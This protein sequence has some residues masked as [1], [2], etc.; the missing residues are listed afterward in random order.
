MDV[1]ALLVTVACFLALGGLFW[2]CGAL[3]EKRS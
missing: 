1:V 3:M 2:L